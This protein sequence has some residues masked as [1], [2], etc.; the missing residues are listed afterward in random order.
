MSL[1]EIFNQELCQCGHSISEEHFLGKCY[2]LDL[3]GGSLWKGCPCD[4][5]KTMEFKFEINLNEHISAPSAIT[6]K[7]RATQISVAE[8]SVI[9]ESKPKVFQWGG[10]N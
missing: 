7:T 1:E 8:S 3:V 2:A 4:R 6:T 9:G 10:K 5:I